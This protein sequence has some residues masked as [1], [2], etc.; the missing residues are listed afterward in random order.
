MHRRIEK[1]LKANFVKF[2]ESVKIYGVYKATSSN[3]LYK[4][5]NK[6]AMKKI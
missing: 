5:A 6:I 3:I 2:S 4:I 1:I